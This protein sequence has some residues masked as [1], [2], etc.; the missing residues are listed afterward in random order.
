MESLLVDIRLLIASFR[1]H[2]F[3]TGS[4]LQDY[5]SKKNPEPGRN[6]E[7]YTVAIFRLECDAILQIT[8]RGI[9]VKVPCNQ[10]RVYL[11]FFK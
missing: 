7:Y 10:E 11:L 9:S 4:P 2:Q 1:V 5:G 3:E 6:R 8:V